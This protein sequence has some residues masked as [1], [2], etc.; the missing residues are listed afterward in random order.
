MVNKDYQIIL[1]KDHLVQKLSCKYTDT[2]TNTDK[3]TQ[4][5]AVPGPQNGRLLAPLRR[6]RALS[7]FLTFVRCPC[8]LLTLRHLNLFF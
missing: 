8:S 6:N 4:L 5:T 7:L 1:V 2:Q 3:H